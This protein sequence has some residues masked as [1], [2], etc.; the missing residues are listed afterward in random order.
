MVMEN[1][2]SS[3]PVRRLGFK[4][5]VPGVAD[6]DQASE[7][8][9]PKYDLGERIMADHRRVVAATRKRLGQQKEA[10]PVSPV[11]RLCETTTDKDD[12]S[13]RRPPEALQSPTPLA[14][15]RPRTSG[16][17][18]HPVMT[19]AQCQVIA[20]IVARDIERLCSGERF[21]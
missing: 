17:I 5:I 11:G 15:N 12:V 13:Q 16:R 21:F 6:S 9:V 14:M 4:E 10:S 2:D 1:L 8:N 7:P 3:R 18:W 19:E 20:R